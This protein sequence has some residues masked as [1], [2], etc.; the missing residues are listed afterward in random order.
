MVGGLDE[1][2]TLFPSLAKVTFQPLHSTPTARV[3][4]KALSCL[5]AFD[6]VS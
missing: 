4:D 2:P 1:F 6:D 3:V 5:V